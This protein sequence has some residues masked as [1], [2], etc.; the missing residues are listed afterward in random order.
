MS[1]SKLL[2]CRF[3]QN[4]FSNYDAIHVKCLYKRADNSVCMDVLSNGRCQYVPASDLNILQ[5]TIEN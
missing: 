4:C 5:L 1:L 3:W 2:C